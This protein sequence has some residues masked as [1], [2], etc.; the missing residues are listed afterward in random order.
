ML[1]I[2]LAT[3][4]PHK[5]D[6]INKIVKGMDLEFVLPPDDFNPVEDGSS[7]E[8][9]AFIKAKEA[10]ENSNMLTLADDSGL[11]VEAL[12]GAPGLHSARYAGTQA[13]KIEKLLK[14]LKDVPAEKRD[15]KFVCAMVL[16]DKNGEVLFSDRGE[17]FGSIAFEA[18]GVNGFGYDPIFLV[19]GGDLTMAELSED[20][21]NTIS[22][23]AVALHKLISFL[24]S[25]KNNF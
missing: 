3:A 8:E 12:D 15:A 22:H 16:L 23:R 10:N 4:N 7:F 20:V 5:V 14:A 11:C 17:C 25:N 9:N 19:E 2:I 13:E 18:R 1:K 21:K 6:E 24:K